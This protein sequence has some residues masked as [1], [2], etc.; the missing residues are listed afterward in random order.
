MVYCF[1]WNRTRLS[2]GRKR[3]VPGISKGMLTVVLKLLNLVRPD[4]AYFGEK[5]YQQLKSS[6]DCAQEFFI[7]TE[8]VPCPDGA[9]EQ[10]GGG[11]PRENYVL[12]PEAKQKQHVCS[13]L[14][15]PT[16]TDQASA[17]ALRRERCGGNSRGH[18]ERRLPAAFVDRCSLID[19]VPVDYAYNH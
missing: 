14:N 10:S 18:W 7:P 2:D 15:P 16:L 9:R 12:S 3:S 4:R 8:I 13:G 5:D 1:A 17:A 19:N 6:T 11:Q